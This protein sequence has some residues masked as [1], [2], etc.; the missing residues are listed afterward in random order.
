MAP[1]MPFPTLIFTFECS[2]L[3]FFYQRWENE[4]R[5]LTST[6]ACQHWFCRVR[7]SSVK[8]SVEFQMGMADFWEFKRRYKLEVCWGIVLK[9]MVVLCCC[10]FHLSHGTV[11]LEVGLNLSSSGGIY[12][13]SRLHILC[14]LVFYAIFLDG[15]IIS[16]VQ[17][18]VL[19]I[20]CLV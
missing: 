2:L 5:V 16:L 15:G 3:I 7:F 20:L 11:I 6:G 18:L 13:C 1:H 4:N 19:A 9:I 12:L 17:D 8:S 10:V 14:V